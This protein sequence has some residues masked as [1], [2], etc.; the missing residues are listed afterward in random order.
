MVMA[1]K[2]D[3]ISQTY[4]HL[5]GHN[6]T[7]S[8]DGG[9]LQFLI[10]E[11]NVKS[12]V[13]IGCGPGGMVDMARKMDLESIGIDG[14]YN[15]ARDCIITHDFITGPIDIQK[16][17]LVWSVEFLEHLEERFLPNVFETIDGAKFA[18]VT[19]APKGVGG[20]HHVNCQDAPY[21]IDRFADEGWSFDRQLTKDVRLVSTMGREFVRETGM[22]FRKGKVC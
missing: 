19:H 1:P 8:L 5:G 17:D 3:K 10:K 6:S 21:W 4:T 12:M 18:F 14:D 13:D 15:Q 20:Y 7:T 11:C 16:F 2:P 9:A 22:I